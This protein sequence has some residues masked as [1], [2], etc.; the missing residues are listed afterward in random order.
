[1][2]RVLMIGLD[3]FELSLAE[4]MMAEGL[5]PRLKSLRD[6]GA[7]FMLDHG[8]AKYSGLAW[9]HVSSGVS[10]DDGGRWSAVFFDPKTYAVKQSSTEAVPFTANLPIRTVAFDLPYCDLW[11]A[12][13]MRGMA[14]WGA[15]DPGVPTQY[16]PSD[17]QAE[18]DARFGPYPARRSIYGFTWP[19]VEKTQRLVEDLEKA[20]RVRAKAAKW[21]L[22]ERFPDWD[23]GIV[24]VSEP[25]SAAEPLWHGVDASHPLHGIASAAASGAG[26]RRIY[27]AI[28]DLIGTLVD[29][30]GDATI[31]T[32]AM[33]GMGR[34]EADVPAMALLPE[35]LYRHSF[36]RPYFRPYPWSGTLANGL[37]LLAEHENWKIVTDAIVPGPGKLHK[38]VAKWARKLGMTPPA[39]F[40]K[41]SLSWM[42]TARYA[43]FWPRMRAFALPS[44]YDGRIRI[45]LRGRER[46]GLV[47]EAQYSAVVGEIEDLLDECRDIVTGAP[48]V[49]SIHHAGKPPHKLGASEA[50]L[51]VHFRGAPT[52]FSHPTIGE[53][54]PL[55]YRRTGG[56]TGEWGFLFLGGPE[57]RPRAY[58]VASAFDVVPTA[59][60]LLGVSG[61]VG[62]SGTSLRLRFEAS[63]TLDRAANTSR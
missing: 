52:G 42:P 37:P 21:L 14:N 62:L 7:R 15:H 54:G 16:R 26:L 58:K 38:R 9:E 11:R 57:I 25:H 3:G 43:R 35:L 8:S 31:M 20:V 36:G 19:S 27:R 5:L 44:Y 40:E 56:H 29:A 12:G 41:S 63:S 6:G 39:G 4:A 13:D 23:L 2:A 49:E 32:F 55:P 18:F 10:P 51:Y 60:D 30:F 45:N 33:H 53:I 61:P 50:D 24:V 47:P 46:K 59:L 22:G 48:V 17:L 1:M 34:N 28:D